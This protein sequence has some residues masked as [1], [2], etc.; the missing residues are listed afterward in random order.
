MGKGL[1]AWDAGAQCGGSSGLAG[2]LA[3]VVR[4]GA[5]A[6]LFVP[7]Q[8]GPP[9]PPVGVLRGGAAGA[10]AAPAA[11]LSRAVGEVRGTGAR[12]PACWVGEGGSRATPPSRT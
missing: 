10:A 2:G 3:G 9:S 4:R 7:L 12:E 8:R 11:A 6:A 5:P 1:W